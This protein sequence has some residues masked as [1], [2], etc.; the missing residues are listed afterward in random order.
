[1]HGAGENAP[2]GW[3]E[4]G[5]TG[6]RS[7]SLLFLS[8]AR[9]VAS[10]FIANAFQSDQQRKAFFAKGGTTVKK[11]L[12]STRQPRDTPDNST[13]QPIQREAGNE[14][15][16]LA[17]REAI[18]AP[19]TPITTQATQPRQLPNGVW[20]T[21]SAAEMAESYVMPAIQSGP[22][23]TPER[24]AALQRSVDS[25]KVKHPEVIPAY[26]NIG[27][28][29]PPATPAPAPTPAPVPI[30]T[31]PYVNPPITPP[32]PTPTPTPAPVTPN[33]GT[34]TGAAASGPS[35][36]VPAKPDPIAYK[37]RLTPK[38]LKKTAAQYTT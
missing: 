13:A 5:Y 34:T 10:G 18:A 38:M 9:R 27:S 30:V 32:T 1:M 21:R 20:E 24:L 7:P 15:Q 29:I 31:P 17:A 3:D 19:A 26:P 25:F 22:P 37:K 36:N 8:N 4:L 14:A 11:S 6:N 12:P 23:L 35:W 16:Q 28:V 33:Y 2:L